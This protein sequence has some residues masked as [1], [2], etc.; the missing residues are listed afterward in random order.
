MCRKS[1]VVATIPVVMFAVLSIWEVFGEAAEAAPPKTAEIASTTTATSATLTPIF[2]STTGTL[3]GFEAGQR[4]ALEANADVNGD[5]INDIIL[6]VVDSPS[7]PPSAQP[8]KYRVFVTNGATG[9][10]LL[11][12]SISSPAWY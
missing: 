4:A 12:I 11:N 3:V 2:D 7:P 8:A 1:I 6:V 10:T 9:L 5:G